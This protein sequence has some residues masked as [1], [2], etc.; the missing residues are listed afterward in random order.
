MTI[1]ES[2]IL[3]LTEC[4]STIQDTFCKLAHHDTCA[5]SLHAGGTTHCNTQPSH[6]KVITLIDEGVMIV[7]ESPAR[8]STDDGPELLTNGTHLVTF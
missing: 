6:L 2:N 4:I 3:A 8:I 1:C 7:N 5:R